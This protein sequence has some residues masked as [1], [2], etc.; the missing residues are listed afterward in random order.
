MLSVCWTLI[1][2]IKK[3]GRQKIWRPEDLDDLKQCFQLA[4]ENAKQSSRQLHEMMGQLQECLQIKRNKH[5][6][7]DK[8]VELNLIQSVGEILGT[9]KHRSKKDFLANN[10]DDFVRSDAD[11]STDEEAERKKRKEK[12][13]KSKKSKKKSSEKVP[14]NDLFDAESGTYYLK[15]SIKFY[16]LKNLIYFI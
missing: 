15:R 14:G 1:K 16:K 4:Q 8:L 11:D 13:K 10:M 5:A 9:K 2:G 12:K 3:L 6:V 7:A